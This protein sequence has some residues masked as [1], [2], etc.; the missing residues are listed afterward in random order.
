L[1][2]KPNSN[3]HDVAFLRA[4]LIALLVLSLVGTAQIAGNAVT[5]MLPQHVQQAY[6]TFPG[7]NGKI[8]FES[9]GHIYVMNAD[10][11]EQTRLLDGSGIDG[12]ASRPVW[13]P[14]GNRIALVGPAVINADGSGLKWLPFK[15]LGGY[16]DSGGVSWSPDGT[17]LIIGE[18]NYI[19]GTRRVSIDIINSTD[20][21]GLKH[22]NLSGFD[23]NGLY[24]IF[25]PEFSPDGKKIALAAE[26]D[27]N[28]T[29]SGIYMMN[30]DGSDVKFVTQSALGFDWSP[31]GKKFVFSDGLSSI[32]AVNADGSEQKKIIDVTPSNNGNPSYYVVYSHALDPRWSPDGTKVVLQIDTRIAN[33]NDHTRQDLPQIFTA[34]SDGS[35]LR[36]IAYG[37]R[38]IWGTHTA[39]ITPVR[40]L[41][42]EITT[43]DLK[44]V[45]VGGVWTTIRNSTD[46]TVIETGYTPM[47]F[48]GFAG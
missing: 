21:S 18:T 5:G 3:N 27:L 48:T 34:N 16:P 46:G 47:T 26:Y 15:G 30:V 2:R 4:F 37:Y 28:Y 41:T 1:F 38:P 14:D 8:A 23:S 33:L 20:G 45:G 36:L 43:T 39:T 11:N 10:G 42:L 17:Q 29:K 13:S 7:A 12:H 25:N 44:G 22:V 6:A 19:N 40:P 9:G 32:Y 35:D 31:D 24:G